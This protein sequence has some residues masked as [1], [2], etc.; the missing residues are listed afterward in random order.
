MASQ[1]LNVCRFNPTAG[2]T[3]DWTYSGPV[4][5]YQSPAAAGAVNGAQYSYRAESS[6]LSQW[7]IGYGTYT[8]GV[9]TRGT[10]LFNSAGTTAKI[11][12]SAAPQVAI[13]A[14]K[15]DLPA[16]TLFSTIN[17]SASGT[18]IG[19]AT[20]NSAAAID[21]TI[22]KAAAS[23]ATKTT[24]LSM[25]VGRSF[26][27]PVKVFKARIAGS[28]DQ[29]YINGGSPNINIKLFGK[30]GAAPANGT[31][32]IPLHSIGFYDTG[33]ESTEREL[34]SYDKDTKWD[35]VWLYI[36]NQ[37]VTA[38]NIFISQ[39]TVFA[40]NERID[41]NP[42]P[43]PNYFDNPALQFWP[44]G[45]TFSSFP[46]GNGVFTAAR[47][48][49]ASSDN[50]ANLTVSLVN[51]PAGAGSRAVKLQRTPGSTRAAHSAINFL[52]RMPTDK[53]VSLRGKV[54]T[55]SF[56]YQ[57][58]ANFSYTA[59]ANLLSAS[60]YASAQTADVVPR[61]NGGA[62][63][64][65]PYYFFNGEITAPTPGGPWARF[66]F[67]FTMPSDVSSLDF[68]IRY[69]PDTAA[70]GA[71]DS[72]TL[73]N[74]KLEQGYFSTPFV[75]PDEAVNRHACEAY[76][77]T[78]YVD[79]TAPG[80]DTQS[81]L[82]TDVDAATS[83]TSTRG[84]WYRYEQPMRATPSTLT[85]YAKDGSSGVVQYNSYSSNT[86]E[87]APTLL[88]SNREGFGTWLNAVASGLTA[89]NAVLKHYHFVAD[90]EI[91]GT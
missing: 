85:F 51:G 22:S 39:I 47:W 26:T 40:A 33:N 28:N 30:Q 53:V 66:A 2:G 14:L 57:V 34:I 49:A 32:G 90:A 68:R 67:S 29:G 83:T 15:E 74:F 23:C 12:F 64:D 65:N 24:S 80:L 6:D 61:G 59:G 38:T 87:V 21:G 13:V 44:R 42:I 84:S 69:Y 56:D 16:P 48:C 78:T 71:D 11:N 54:V 8:S 79:D 4:T 70:A 43:G 31:D 89:G 81:G 35:H 3:T 10:V 20:S 7:E 75:M 82:V 41:L 52:Q 58:G 60:V 37:D 91:Y 45:T 50:S 25:Y 36:E 86:N 17:L 55:I 76:Y 88:A 63:T 19:D 72:M 18:Y 46:T 77:R 9:L 5:G 1:F 73:A 62:L 27:T